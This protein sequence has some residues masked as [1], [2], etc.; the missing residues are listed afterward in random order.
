MYPWLDR[1]GRLSPLKLL[2][3]VGLFLPG[4]WTASNLALGTLGPR[5]ITEAID[6]VGLWA[7]RFLFVSL[8]V[9]PFR[10]IFQWTPLIQVRRKIGRAHV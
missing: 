6:D 9:T 1:S 2:V 10:Q 8:A 7:I 5:P 3:F 4:A